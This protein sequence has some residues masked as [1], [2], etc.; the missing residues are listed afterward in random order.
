MAYHREL[1]SPDRRP[2]F[3]DELRLREDAREMWGWTWLD[4]LHQDLTYGARVLRNA[5]GFTLTAMLVLVLGIGVPLSAFRVVLTDLRGRLGTGPGFA[6]PSDAP[7]AGRAHDEPDVSRAGL[8]CRQ[9]DVVPQH[10]RRIA[11]QSGS[12]QRGRSRQRARVHTGAGQ[13]G[14]CHLQ[15]LS[16][17]RHRARARPRA[18]SRR[19]ARG[20]GA[21]GGHRRVVLAA[22]AR[23]GSRGHRPKYSCERQ[24]APGGRR[25]AALGEDQRR[26]LDAAGR[27]AVCGRRQHAAHRLE[28]GP[29]SV[30]TSPAR[31]VSAGVATGNARSRRQPARAAARSRLEGRVS[32]GAADSP[33]RQ[34]QRGVHDS[35]DR[36]GVGAAAARRGLRQSRDTRPG[37]RRDARTRD[38]RPHGAG[39]QPSARRAPAVHRVAPAGGTQ[40]SVCAASQ[41][42]R[43]ES[44]SAA[45]EFSRKRG[46]GL[47]R[48]RRHI[49]RRDAG[50]AR[51]RAAAGISA[52]QPGAAC[53]T[54]Q[55]D[56]PRR[57]G[58]RERSAARCVQPSGQQRAAAWRHRSRL[59]LPP[60]RLDFAGPERPWLRG[61]RRAGVF[62][63]ASCADCRISGRESDIPGLARALEQPP[64]GSELAGAPVR[65]QSRGSAIPGHD[66]DAPRCVAATSGRAKTAWRSSAKRR[67]AC[68]GRTQIQTMSPSANRCRGVLRTR[69]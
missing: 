40:R 17:V 60:S 15:L 61:T 68:C 38:S 27:A 8:L 47:A 22:A 67:R 35:A 5:P 52:R 1:M 32:R 9:R 63:S 30:W 39:C 21:G 31:G 50:S 45:A 33:V 36:H 51:L 49:L 53:R 25:D 23:R 44:D 57:T 65:G 6:R 37:P 56:I 42:R 18:D 59:R 3:G 58:G 46:S 14:V 12:L 41:H 55:H 29:R 10:R 13:R 43:L 62:R 11:A 24:A 48:A 64:H 4:R 54:G 69:P 19:R 7:R 20:C 26:H 16:R 34:Q 28:L 66:G 2:S